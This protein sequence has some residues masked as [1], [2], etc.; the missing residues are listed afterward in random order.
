MPRKPAS[1]KRGRLSSIQKRKARVRDYKKE[2]AQRKAKAAKLGYKSVRE[3]KVA[4]KKVAPLKL[5]PKQ[6][7]RVVGRTKVKRNQNK[8][9]K[10]FNDLVVKDKTMTVDAFIDKYLR[11]IMRLFGSVGKFRG[12]IRL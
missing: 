4:R 5:K 11:A 1:P 6:M 10:T 12:R 8:I 2:Y 9:I 7:D 3:Y